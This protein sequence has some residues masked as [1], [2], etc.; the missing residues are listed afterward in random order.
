MKRQLKAVKIDC[1][2][3]AKDKHKRLDARYWV[4]KKELVEL[5]IEK[6]RLED[7]L[8]EIEDGFEYTDAVDERKA[9]VNEVS[10]I[11]LKMFK[12]DG[13]IGKLKEMLK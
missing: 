4:R 3:I 11:S 6:N 8:G 7:R 13:R 5:E 12:I 2:D 9:L 10:E 1:N